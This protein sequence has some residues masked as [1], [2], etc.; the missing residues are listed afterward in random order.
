MHG[1]LTIH[2]VTKGVTLDAEFLGK[3]RTRGATTASRS[4]PRPRST[5]RTSAS[6]WNQA[7]EAGGVLV[8]EKVTITTE[9]QLV[10]AK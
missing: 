10:A 5:A 9:V 7:L 6:T 1:D 8:G 3:G 2:G 4:A